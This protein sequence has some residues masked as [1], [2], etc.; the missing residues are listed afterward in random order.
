[1]WFSL[2]GLIGLG[3]VWFGLDTTTARPGK[4]PLSDLMALARKPFDVIISLF[5]S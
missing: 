3:L 2:F 5:L 4:Y 1:M